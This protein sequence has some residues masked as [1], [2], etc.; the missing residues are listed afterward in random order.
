[1]HIGELLC[2]SPDPA[3][4]VFTEWMPRQAD[5]AVFTVDLID[6]VLAQLTVKV[7][8]KNAEETG[9]GS[10]AGT[11]VTADRTAGLKVVTVSGLKEM[12]RYQVEVVG[13]DANQLGGLLYR[14]L[15]ATWFNTARAAG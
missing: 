2:A 1:M 14:F 9:S 4:I 15:P 11:I 7:F 10:L 8:H 13:S 3:A 6:A 5:N 12:V